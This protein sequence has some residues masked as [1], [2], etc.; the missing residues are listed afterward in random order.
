MSAGTG[1]R[2]DRVP[3]SPVTQRREVRGQSWGVPVLWLLVGFLKVKN[4]NESHQGGDKNGSE[5]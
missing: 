2:E 3:S 1:L 5:K 4:L